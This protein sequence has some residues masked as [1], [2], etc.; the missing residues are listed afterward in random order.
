MSWPFHRISQR[1]PV[2]APAPAHLTGHVDV[3][4]EVHLDL[5]RAVPGAC[6]ASPPLDVERE[7]PRLVPTRPGLGCLGEERSDLVEELGV[8]G[9]VGPRGAA[10]RGLVDVDHLVDVLDPLDLLVPSRHHPGP[11][12][13]VG[14]CLPEDLLDQRRLARPRHP[15]D[16]G[17]HPER[18]VD[19][20]P[21][22]VVLG[23]AP[24]GDRLSV[25]LPPDER[26]R[27]LTATRQV[28]PGDRVGL[29]GD[30]GERR[31]RQRRDPRAR[32]L[33]GRCRRCGRPPGSCPRRAR[34]RS[35]CCPG[36][37]DGAGSRSAAGCPAGGARSRARR[38]C[39]APRPARSR[40]GW[41]V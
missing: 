25:A 31:P 21:L 3:G 15:G 11:V 33:P 32:R 20:D 2:V 27:D 4:Q 5:D 10:D 16:R 13:P 12:H 17:E 39:R 37:E 38:G 26:D 14:Q 9:R 22:E 28:V 40:S 23:G 18:E 34:P 29:G 35:G 41:R 36:R 6:L 7:S 24:D 8:G 30:V 19:V 1:L